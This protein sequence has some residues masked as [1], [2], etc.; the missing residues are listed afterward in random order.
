[1]AQRRLRY[2]KARGGFVQL[3]DEINYPDDMALVR[4][5]PL[6]PFVADIN[7]TTITID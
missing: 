1:M 2:L 6:R 7:E 5:P 4:W 3:C